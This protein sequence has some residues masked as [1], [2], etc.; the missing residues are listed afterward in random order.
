[1][2]PAEDPTPDEAGNEMA[3]QFDLL[4]TQIQETFQKLEQLVKPYVPPE[5]WAS[6]EENFRRMETFVQEGR[7]EMLSANGQ[8]QLSSLDAVFASD[9]L[10]LV[11]QKLSEIN[12]LLSHST[13]G[14]AAC[15]V[16]AVQEILNDIIHI[17]DWVHYALYAAE[18]ICFFVCQ[19]ALPVITVCEQIVDA[20]LD[21][22]R[23][24]RD[25]LDAAVPTKADPTS[26]HIDVSGPYPGTDP[27][28]MFTGTNYTLSLY[29]DF[30]NGGFNKFIG[31]IS[32]LGKIVL[33]LLDIDL[34]KITVD[35]VQVPSSAVSMDTSLINNLTT[36]DD[37]DLGADAHTLQVNGLPVG[38]TMGGTD[39]DVQATCGPY[40]YPDK[41]C[42]GTGCSGGDVPEY[43][44]HYDVTVID[45]PIIEN[46]QW[47]DEWSG[48]DIFG[49]GFSTMCGDVFKVYWNGQEVPCSCVDNLDWRRFTATCT[50]FHEPGRIELVLVDPT[51]P[52]NPDKQ[53]HGPS[54]DIGLTPYDALTIYS[55]LPSSSFVGDL[56]TVVG[57]HFSPYPED[58]LITFYLDQAQNVTKT[59]HPLDVSYD[60][61]PGGWD[62]LTFK[63]PE[64]LHEY[65]GETIP[66]RVSLEMDISYGQFHAD[67]EFTPRR[68]ESAKWGDQ[69]MIAFGEAQ[70]YVRSAVVGDVDGD[71]IND[72]VVG[73]AEDRSGLGEVMGAV[74]IAFGPV[75]GVSLPSGQQYIDLDIGAVDTHWDV[76]ISGDYE[77]CYLSGE[78]CRRIGTSLA[79]GDINGDGIKDLLIGSTDQNEAGLHD[80]DTASYQ[81]NKGHIPGKAYVFYGRPR[82]QWNRWY[83]IPMGE[84]DV[85]IHG[86]DQRELGYQVAIGNLNGDGFADMVISAPAQPFNASRPDDD[87]SGKVYVVFG[88]GALPHDIDVGSDVPSAVPGVVISGESEWQEYAHK[89]DGLGEG[90]ALGDINGDGLDD[91]LVGAPRFL[92]LC[93]GFN[94]KGT[95]YLFYGSSS[96][97]GPS[98][99]LKAALW[100]GDQDVLILGPTPPES[101]HPMHP[102]WEIGRVMA[103]GDLNRDGKGEV[104]LSA[105]DEFLD[106]EYTYG[107]A[108]M[109]IQEDHI[110][111]IYLLDGSGIPQSGIHGVGGLARAAVYGSPVISRLGSSLA[112]SDV[113]SNGFQD[114]LAGAPGRI[115]SE[116]PGSVWGFHGSSNLPTGEIHLADRSGVP[117]DF[118]I[119]GDQAHPDS[120]HGFGTFVTS[121]DLN[122][123]VGNDVLIVDPLARAP[124]PSSPGTWRDGA[125]MLYVFYEGGEEFWP[126]AVYPSVVTMDP[127]DSEQAFRAYRGKAPYLFMWDSANVPAQVELVTEYGSRSALVRITGC[128]P[129]G[130][131]SLRLRVYDS[132]AQTGD[133]V[134]TINIRPPDIDVTPMNI[135]FGDVYIQHTTSQ[136]VAIS[137]VDDASPLYINSIYMTGSLDISQANDCPA[138]LLPH[139]S[140][141]VTVSFSPTMEGLSSGTL[142]IRSNDPDEETVDV[143]VRGNALAR[144]Q[145]VVTGGNLVF[146]D[147]VVGKS[148]SQDIQ[149]RNEGTQDLHIG[150]VSLSGA[151]EFAITANDCIGTLAPYNAAS[152]ETCSITVTFTPTGTDP[153]YGTVTINS[154]DPDAPVFTGSLSGNGAAPFLAAE[155]EAIDFGNAKTEALLTIQN[156]NASSN[157]EW[158]IQDDLPPWLSASAMRGEVA[159]G[160]LERI[161]LFANRAGL[162]IGTYQHA[163]S[164][165]S[166]G[167]DKEID[168]TMTVPLPLAAFAHTFGGEGG[169]YASSVQPTSDGGFIVTGL[170]N[171][172]GAGAED[173]WGLKL[174]G[175]GYIQWEKTLGGPDA[176]RGY[177]I[178]QT[179]DGGYIVAAGS[180]SFE[181][182]YGLW[183][184]KLNQ[185]G[186]VEW[187]REYG[188][189]V[190]DNWGDWGVNFS[191]RQTLDGGY[192]VAGNTQDPGFTAGG[193]DAWV[194]KLDPSGAVEWQK[195]YGRMDDDYANWVEETDDGGF[196]VCG[197]TESFGAGNADIW[198]LKLDSSG[199]VEWQKAYGG[200]D[201]DYGYSI[202]ETLDGG[203]V[204]LGTSY[205]FGGA[206]VLKLDAAGE[207]VWQ[208]TYGGFDG[209]GSAISQTQDGGYIVAGSY[210]RSGRGD[211]AW[212]FKL[213]P[214][215]TLEWQRTFGGDRV[216]VAHYVCQTPDGGFVTAGYTNSFR[217]T[218]YDSGNYDL[219]VIRTDEWGNIGSSCGVED[220][221]AASAAPTTIVPVDTGA[222]SEDTTATGSITTVE[223]GDSLADTQTVCSITVEEMQLME[224]VD[225]SV[226]PLSVNLGELP[227][228]FGFAASQEVFIQ[229][230]GR[231][232][233]L[234]LLGITLSGDPDFTFYHDCPAYLLPAQGC[235]VTVSFSPQA[236]GLRSAV[237]TIQS[238][239][240]DEGSLQVDISGTGVSSEEVEGLPQPIALPGGG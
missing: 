183:V 197:V 144:P 158:S 178:R 71:G 69:D 211:D 227:S 123:F 229:N 43:P 105:P 198:V 54:Q 122:P 193:S 92:R 172:Y 188:G 161:M 47:N 85:L 28:L 16:A 195:S 51:D 142:H 22:L 147:V 58:I 5:T 239:D 46:I 174:D 128:L 29:T 109:H 166:N 168:L 63:V 4:L 24:I 81:E 182:N 101:L 11:S 30:S 146:S 201:Y 12:E 95:A 209:T 155:P 62:S 164:L 120:P 187:Q 36:G 104:I 32:T 50:W 17:L 217:T 167:G 57:D 173:V 87:W 149:I 169:E 100:T 90:I 134:A 75:E 205:S 238:D 31:R 116:E 199:A 10:V 140:C 180:L 208:K 74:Y 157:L 86:D 176:E 150:D 215:G 72:L 213:G 237:L 80:L 240:P 153:V 49:L 139:E 52:F 8:E 203:Y 190:D 35:D 64:E 225:I 7:A 160:A 99:M 184:F 214:D 9:I 97:G 118:L 126:V 78:F 21:V 191:I 163:L 138:T 194:L 1:M 96:L 67:S 165:V 79:M 55:V 210:Y 228:G 222:I 132:D 204:L 136:T 18:G 15:N 40:H 66:F 112:V 196:I 68:S 45:A 212:L 236:E 143:G 83:D 41:V 106:Y 59:I 192:V 121:G 200:T 89:G 231:F 186:E 93:D 175:S 88:Q 60:W 230:T 102:G 152:P 98:G 207:V 125:G 94:R 39:L 56:V 181:E 14:E 26:W 48:W 154:D 224:D 232:A 107:T 27:H 91:L 82:S 189:Q 137:N 70:G 235:S 53:K 141:T 202:Q 111:K 179:S 113:N 19:P 223:P 127:C 2:L 114:L 117:D 145:M 159:P 177:D 156:Q 219:W 218:P 148:Q 73:V 65:E 42:V 13:Y 20:V 110:G 119:K 133:A 25:I 76:V 115:G 124:E 38:I 34:G 129:Q 103:I 33:D 151:G 226:S 37:Q 77:G 206:W 23:A 221:S 44:E 6:I 135:D 108:S 220:T 3:A 185:A 84:Y 162:D 61:Q 130:V 131:D 233:P 170:T 216:D 234:H 171:S